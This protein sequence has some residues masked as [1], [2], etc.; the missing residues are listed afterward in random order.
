MKVTAVTLNHVV[1]FYGACFTGGKEGIC[2]ESVRNVG[3]SS[4][5]CPAYVFP[6]I[7]YIKT[8]PNVKFPL[9]LKKAGVNLTHL[10]STSRIVV[11]TTVGKN[12][13]NKHPYKSRLQGSDL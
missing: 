2:S 3:T 6:V 1:R 7:C 10:L 8:R 4:A 12:E 13:F 5:T 9:Y 11:F